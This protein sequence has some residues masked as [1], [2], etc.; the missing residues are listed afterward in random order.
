MINNDLIKSRQ[1]WV[2]DHPARTVDE[3]HM[4]G[5]VHDIEHRDL[6][7]RTVLSIDLFARPVAWRAQIALMYPSRLPRAR[8]S[9]TLP[10]SMLALDIARQLL[11]GVGEPDCRSMTTDAVSFELL[12][13][14]TAEEIRYVLRAAGRPALRLER[15][16]I[17]EIN[18]YDFTDRATQIDGWWNGKTGREEGLYLPQ[19]RTLI[20]AGTDT[21]Q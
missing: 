7:I 11:E 1:R 15:L 19:E 13:P 21:E 5:Y 10:Q 4:P 3:L 6:I 18:Q 9:W 8:A 2:K 20:Y 16:P 17:G 12:H 14:C